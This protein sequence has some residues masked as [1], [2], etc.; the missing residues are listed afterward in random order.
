MM[1]MLKKHDALA[2]LEHYLTA[3]DFEPQV[4]K[5]TWMILFA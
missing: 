5:T 3:N 4:V 1:V 2:A